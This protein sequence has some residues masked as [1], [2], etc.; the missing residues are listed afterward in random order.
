MILRNHRSDR[1]SWRPCFT[2]CHLRT[3]AGRKTVTVEA[4]SE[5]TIRN[6]ARDEKLTD[7]KIHGSIVQIVEDIAAGRPAAD[8]KQRE[9]NV[10]E[11]QAI[12]YAVRARLGRDEGIWT[13]YQNT[14]Q[15]GTRTIRERDVKLSTR[16]AARLIVG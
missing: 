7:G 9:L 13:I 4:R 16:R 12:E 14:L 10:H 15:P 8:T 5:R 6:S 11:I 1:L 3:R 2:H